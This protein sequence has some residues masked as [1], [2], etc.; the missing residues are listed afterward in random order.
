M[1]QIIS[2][3]F[4]A[5]AGA[6]LTRVSIA[7]PWKSQSSTRPG[8]SGQSV[9]E[10]FTRSIE[11]ASVSR[12]SWRPKSFAIVKPR[13]NDPASWGSMCLARRPITIAISPS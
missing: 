9:S 8:P 12:K 1:S 11:P 7:L 4:P 3:V 13:M 2:S 10:P 5:C 6:P